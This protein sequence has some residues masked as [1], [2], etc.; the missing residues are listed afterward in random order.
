M[1]NISVVGK[2]YPDRVNVDVYYLEVVYIKCE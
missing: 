2:S 1:N